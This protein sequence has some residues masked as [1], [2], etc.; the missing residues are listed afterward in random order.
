[1]L[2]RTL[3]KMSDAMVEAADTLRGLLKA[4][5]EGVRLGACKAVLE[6]GTKLRESVD[7]HERIK[8][9]EA[10]LEKPK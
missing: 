1:M 8:E 5:S 2:A 3:G 6:L 7:L 9:L 4:E 10:L